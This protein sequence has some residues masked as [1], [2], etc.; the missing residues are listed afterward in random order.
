MWRKRNPRA[1]LVETQTGA[2]TVENSMDVR[3]KVGNKTI[4]QSSNHTIGHLP[5]KYKNTNT[6]GYMHHYYLQQ[7]NYRSSPNVPQ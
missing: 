6:K 3:Q 7:P 5:P 2:A 4:P 1:L